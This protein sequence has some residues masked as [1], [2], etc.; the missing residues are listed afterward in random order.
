M[1]RALDREVQDAVFEA[2]KGY[3]P[4][5]D[6][7]HPLGCHR[8]RVPDRVCF[9]GL[10]LRLVTGAA[11]TTIEAIM[12]YRVSDTTLRSRRNQWIRAGVFNQLALEAIL[13]YDRIMGLDLEDVAIDGSNH[14]A[15]CGGQQ[16]GY[17]PADRG[18]QGWKWLIAVDAKG[19]PLCFVTD[20]ANRNDYA[21]LPAVLQQLH[22]TGL[23]TD[24]GTLHLDRGFGYPSAPNLVASY[25]IANLN[26]IPRRRP[27]QGAIPIVGLG[28][29]WIVEAAN[30]WLSNYGQLRRNTDRQTAQ[31]HAAIN[32]AITILITSR[33]INHRN[34]SS[35]P[36][37]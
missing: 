22:D 6:R 33:L 34:R 29:R 17:N 36:I 14:K 10:V 32:L 28:K 25:G 19:I 23:A 35:P 30:S 7:S 11:W 4:P 16:T 3:L 26:V 8:R 12:G 27:G 18:K 20:G 1:M 5:P 24:I 37:R 2:V 15:P 13:A 21:L 31:R 9:E